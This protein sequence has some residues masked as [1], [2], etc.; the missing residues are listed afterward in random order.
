VTPHIT[1]KKGSDTPT[2]EE[3]TETSELILSEDGSETPTTGE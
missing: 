1:A 2:D 3:D